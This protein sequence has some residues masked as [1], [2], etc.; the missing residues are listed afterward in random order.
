MPFNPDTHRRRSI[1]LPGFDYASPGAYFVTVVVKHRECLFGDV[2]DGEMR[3][4]DAGRIVDET[5]RRLSDRFPT[6]PD[7]W[8]VMP[9]HVHGVVMWI[10]DP[11][12]PGRDES[13]PYGQRRFIGRRGDIYDAPDLGELVRTFKAITT[14]RIS[15]IGDTFGLPIWQRNYHERII[16]SERHLHAIRAY[17]ANNP[18]E[19][20]T[21]Q[22]RP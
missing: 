1:R 11:A 3:L 6:I 16:R 8:V 22:E 19:W 13:R 14:H 10:P 9:N 5:W 17:I 2:V 21:D 20:E 18:R 4:N 7:S 12:G 15:R